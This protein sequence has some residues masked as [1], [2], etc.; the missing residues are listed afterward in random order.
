M[1]HHL[2]PPPHITRFRLAGAMPAMPRRQ[3]RQPLALAAG[4][5]GLDLQGTAMVT[6]SIE[7]IDHV[8]RGSVNHG[9][10]IVGVPSKS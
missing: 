7:L 5:A 2:L 8:N 4:W 3:I 6:S 1:G 10:L 9:L